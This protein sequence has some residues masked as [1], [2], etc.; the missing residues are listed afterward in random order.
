MG[1]RAIIEALALL[2]LDGLEERPQDASL[3]TYAGKIE[4]AQARLDF[5]AP[6]DLVAR[7]I[8]AYDPKPGAWSILRGTEV[9]LFG[10]RVLPDR[11]G[12]PGKV[13]A[14]GEMGMIV[15]CGTGAVAVETVH[16]AG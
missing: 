11:R 5:S 15:A 4:R 8:R 2:D 6:A 10:V 13:L 7:E 14:T 12:D 9:R 3:V 1:A 16:P